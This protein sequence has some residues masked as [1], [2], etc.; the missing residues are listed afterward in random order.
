VGVGS[1]WITPDWNAVLR[2][3]LLRGRSI[4][5]TDLRSTPRVALVSQSAARELW[6]NADALGKRLLLGHDTARVVG[7]VGDVRYGRIQEPP[8]PDVYVSYYQF[9]MTFRMM[10]FLRAKADPASLVEPARRALREVAPG[11][12]VYDIATLQMRIGG[13][14]A[15]TRFLA[16][17]FSVFAVLALVLATIGAYGVISYSV[18]RRTR[19]M[20]VRIALGATQRDLTRL[21]VGQA[22]VL[23]AAGGALG[24]VGALGAVELIRSRLY[25]VEPTDPVTLAGIVVLLTAVVVI[26]SWIPARRAAGVSAMQALRTG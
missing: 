2:V 10:V 24:L 26:A 25:G 23:A 7:I 12:P 14:L 11:F 5:P 15:E 16:Q 20:G 3:P 22:V 19:E 9:P 21:V 18:A 17:L 13:A 6:P 8:R 1:H 4:Q